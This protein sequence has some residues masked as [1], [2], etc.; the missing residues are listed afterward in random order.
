MTRTVPRFHNWKR[1]WM[2]LA[3]LLPLAGCQSL[4]ATAVC[5]APKPMPDLVR[6]SV[7]PGDPL[8]EMQERIRKYEATRSSATSSSQ[9]PR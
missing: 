7:P 3:V 4:P 1:N 5:P 9:P 6:Q 2:P 8:Q